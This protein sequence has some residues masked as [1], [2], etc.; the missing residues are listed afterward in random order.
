[1]LVNWTS[2]GH[3]EHRGRGNDKKKTYHFNHYIISIIFL[4]Q[5]RKT[6][7]VPK[8]P[9]SSVFSVPSRE[10]SERVVKYY[11][12]ISSFLPQ[13]EMLSLKVDLEF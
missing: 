11:L 13:R 6:L 1:M 7:Q 5:S 2:R 8:T 3:R 9:Y 4:S 10:R 12:K